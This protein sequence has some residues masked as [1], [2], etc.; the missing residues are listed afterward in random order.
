MAGWALFRPDFPPALQAAPSGVPRARRTR[1]TRQ[2]ARPIRDVGFADLRESAARAPCKCGFGETWQS[3]KNS[4]V[5]RDSSYQRLDSI[6]GERLYTARMEWPL[7]YLAKG[8][9]HRFATRAAPGQF[10][11]LVALT[12]QENGKQPALCKGQRR[13]RRRDPFVPIVIG[14]QGR[15]RRLFL[16]RISRSLHGEHKVK[17]VIVLFFPVLTLLRMRRRARHEL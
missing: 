12:F 13:C 2:L 16:R 10:D 6:V 5:P 8:G 15:K 9:R 1:G 4:S 3:A 14:H 7:K 17:M 11:R